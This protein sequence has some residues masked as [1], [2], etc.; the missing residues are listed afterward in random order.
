MCE[1]DKDNKVVCKIK[2]KNVYQMGIS[3]SYVNGSEE[4]A[5][6]E[7]M[8]NDM[9][10]EAIELGLNKLEDF[11]PAGSLYG[12]R[13]TIYKLK[14][15]NMRKDSKYEDGCVDTEMPFSEFEEKIYE[16]V[17]PETD[18]DVFEKMAPDELTEEEEDLF[19]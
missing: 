16:V 1:L 14:D 3:C 6:D 17:A 4:V 12:E 5:F 15:F 7:S 18:K 10:R 8:L 2:G 19:G 9:Q 13:V 11:K